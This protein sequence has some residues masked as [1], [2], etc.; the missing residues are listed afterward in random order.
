V[1]QDD[2]RAVHRILTDPARR[3]SYSTDRRWLGSGIYRCG[4]CDDGSTMRAAPTGDTPSRPGK[5]VWH[6]RCTAYGH[7]SVKQEP[8]DAYVLAAVAE[9]LRDP[10]VVAAM[11]E[12]DPHLDEHLLA[13][14]ALTARLARVE[15]DYDAN[16]LTGEEYRTK[17]DAVLAD[18]GSVQEKI[19]ASTA[20]TVSSPVLSALDPG[21]V[22]LASPIDVQRAVLRSVLVVTVLTATERGAHWSKDRLRVERPGQPEGQAVAS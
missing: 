4:V 15:K 20:R 3:T 19:D 21:A 12:P 13:R 9:K 7:L 22:F 11:T 10:Q 5:Q 17:K 2:W 6:Y 14:E 1:S 18:L 8:T 16:H